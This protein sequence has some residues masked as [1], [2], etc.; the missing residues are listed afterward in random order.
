MRINNFYALLY[1]YSRSL[2]MQHILFRN[3]PWI[4]SASPNPT[5]PHTY[6][7]TSL[8][9]KTS[10]SLKKRTDEVLPYSWKEDIILVYSVGHHG[11][12]IL[13]ERGI[14]C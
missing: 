11:H 14:Y 7:R 9:I 8:H 3:L 6:K 13:P 12:I 1:K 5:Y 2:F 4:L 10:A